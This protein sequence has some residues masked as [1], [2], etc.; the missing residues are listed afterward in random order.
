MPEDPWQHR[1]QQ[2]AEQ[3]RRENRVRTRQ[4]LQPGVS[5]VEFLADG[6]QRVNFSG[7]DYLGLSRH[8]SVLT[9][10]SETAATVAGAGASALVTGY[11]PEHQDLE[12]A[13]ARF[14][15][16]DAA[17]VFSSGYLANLAL[18]SALLRRGDA[19]VEDKLNHASLIDAARLSDAQL[20]RY[21]HLDRH[22]AD[23][24]LSRHADGERLLVSDGVFSMDG[25]CA[26][27][28]EL[29][30]LA[31]RHSA[32]LCIDDAHGIGVVGDRGR[33]SVAAA[34]LDQ[35]QVPVMIGTLGKT[36]GSGGAFITGPADLM[37]HLVQTA[38]S[39]IYTTAM[40]PAQAAAATAALEVLETDASRHTRLRANIQHF[41][42]HAQDAG[43]PLQD[44][45]TAIQPL[46]LGS[47]SAALTA[48]DHLLKQGYLVAAIRP[49]TVPEGSAR[50]RITL[51]SEHTDHQIKGLV[52]AMSR[53]LSD[54][55]ND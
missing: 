8:P 17:V 41:R 14:F 16:R 12:Q 6:Q 28:Q 11:R 26:P 36:L 32:L 19:I 7:N 22:A 31:A 46:I 51:C 40:P 55:R 1:L 24:Q 20:H 39:Y 38:R 2:A 29:V 42:D 23:R 44:S 30:D 50:L 21:P 43:L 25:D 27:L 5:A 10:G 37:D 33:G 35:D 34:G 53:C 18:A 47:E 52:D 3:R 48:S 13:L 45:Q 49:P 9:A 15:Q 4:V 54:H